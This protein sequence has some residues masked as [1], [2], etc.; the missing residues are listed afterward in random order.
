MDEGQREVDA[1][2]TEQEEE[3]DGGDGEEV[4]EDC[5]CILVVCSFFT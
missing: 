2:E 3:G 5:L 1:A 4:V